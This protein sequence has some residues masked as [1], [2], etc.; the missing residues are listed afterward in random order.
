[1]RQNQDQ[2]R[3]EYGEFYPARQSF[4]STSGEST[5]EGHVVGYIGFLTVFAGHNFRPMCLNVRACGFDIR[6]ALVL[7]ALLDS[8]M[9]IVWSQLFTELQGRKLNEPA[10]AQHVETLWCA[11]RSKITKHL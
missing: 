4:A 1:M 10:I 11:A 3:S 7:L 6:Y 2:Y 5:F 9:H 8:P